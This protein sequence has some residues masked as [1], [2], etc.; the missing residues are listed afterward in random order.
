M[1]KQLNV[2][3]LAP[4]FG[5]IFMLILLFAITPET[6]QAAPPHGFGQGQGRTGPVLESDYHTAAWERFM[7][8]YHF[9]SGMDYRFD[10]GWATF[11]DGFVPVDVYTV[12]FRSDAQVSLR[13][14]AYG[15]FSGNFQTPPSNIFFPTHIN[16][17]FYVPF[18]LGRPSTNPILNPLSRD[19]ATSTQNAHSA[20]NNGF[21]PPTSVQ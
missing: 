16:P 5:A 12:N 20:P 19:T 8:N 6:T 9:V 15:I 10:L 14:P 4:V 11:W 1:K 7:F 21:L 18:V 3:L 2:K 13:P 17:A